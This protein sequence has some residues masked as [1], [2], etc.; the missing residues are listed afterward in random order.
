MSKFLL[1]V[2]VLADDNSTELDPFPRVNTSRGVV[3]GKLFVRS[4]AIFRS[5]VIGQQYRIAYSFLGIPFAQP[6]LGELK[7]QAIIF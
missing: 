1:P 3:K 6:P 4:N 7:F 2:L 5:I